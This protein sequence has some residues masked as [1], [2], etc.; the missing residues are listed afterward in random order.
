MKTLIL[1]PLGNSTHHEFTRSLAETYRAN[2][3]VDWI[4]TP[5]VSDVSSVR[6]HL[7]AVF[8]K[9]TA[10]IALWIDSDQSWTPKCVEAVTLPIQVG[11]AELVTGYVAFKR[12]GLPQ[13]NVTPWPKDRSKAGY[14]G[15][16]HEIDGFRYAHVQLCGAGFLAMSRA[17]VLKAQQIVPSYTGFAIKLEAP[18][19][20]E[21]NFALFHPTIIDG[22]RYGED[23]AAC[24]TFNKLGIDIWVALDTRVTHYDG[25]LGYGGELDID[26]YARRGIP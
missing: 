23:I 25:N 5:A 21:R 22:E 11:D 9:T 19:P 7:L 26:E 20:P 1:T 14:T 6:N 18:G 3:D 10:N 24:K 4:H 13:Y 8:L 15:A 2:K 12:P 17:V 16:R